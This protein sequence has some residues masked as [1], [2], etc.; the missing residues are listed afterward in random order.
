MQDNWLLLSPTNST[1]HFL[2]PSL[3]QECMQIQ[4]YLTIDYLCMT[5]AFVNNTQIA[6]SINQISGFPSI[7]LTH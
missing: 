7:L 6:L 3:S 2:H 1:L 5:R 4:S